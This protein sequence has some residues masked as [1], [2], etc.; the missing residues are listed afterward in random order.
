MNHPQINLKPGSRK[1][2]ST[3]T[4]TQ[5]ELWRHDK[6]PKTTAG[7]KPEHIALTSIA[8]PTANPTS[9]NP[10]D[11]NAYSS[12]QNMIRQMKLDQE[13]K[14]EQLTREG[15]RVR[16]DILKTERCKRCGMRTPHVG[17]CDDCHSQAMLRCEEWVAS[18]KQSSIPDPA[19]EVPV[20]QDDPVDEFEKHPSQPDETTEQRKAKVE[21]AV[22]TWKCVSSSLSTMEPWQL[23]L[24]DDSKATTRKLAETLLKTQ[25]RCECEET[26]L[27]IDYINN[28]NENRG[29]N[30][31][32]VVPLQQMERLLY[33]IPDAQ[34]MAFFI[35]SHLPEGYHALLSCT[36]IFAEERTCVW[37]NHVLFEGWSEKE[38]VDFACELARLLPDSETI[39]E[40]W[41]WQGFLEVL[42]PI[43]I[44]ISSVCLA[45][46]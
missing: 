41:K 8:E 46:T 21:H 18:V 38:N 2:T 43:M 1:R 44:S 12:I 17:I 11:D 16:K 39:F 33:G 28:Q 13:M 15:R 42:I 26:L 36:T 19:L 20:H 7:D 23:I 5:D 31:V 3:I 25:P 24:G 32:K 6:K 30:G 22:T 40:W 27:G 34:I 37:R 45:Q 35:L 10:D 9:A 14:T 4:A 29:R